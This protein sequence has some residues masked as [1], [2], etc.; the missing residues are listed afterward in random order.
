MKGVIALLLII[1]IL[2][3]IPILSGISLPESFEAKELGRF[4]GAVLRYWLDL[5]K[6][7]FE[8]ISASLAWMAY[9]LAE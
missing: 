6:S 1:L 2:F 8:K 7:C 4:L 3:G 5:I 9:S